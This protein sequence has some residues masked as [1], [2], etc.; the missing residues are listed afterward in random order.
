MLL[1][2][3]D[4]SFNP[5]TQSANYVIRY[6]GQ[7]D[8]LQ[9]DFSCHIVSYAFNIKDF[10]VKMLTL[11]S[12]S[13]T[14]PSINFQQQPITFESVFVYNYKSVT[15]PPEMKRIYISK[16]QAYSKMPQVNEVFIFESSSSSS[17]SNS[18]TVET[19][20]LEISITSSTT[21]LGFTDSIIQI[22]GYFS[23]I[24]YITKVV[25]EGSNVINFNSGL[26]ADSA[27][28]NIDFTNRR[29]SFT[30]PFL[31]QIPHFVHVEI[32]QFMTAI[33]DKLYDQA[34]GNQTI[35][36]RDNIDTIGSRS[37]YSCRGIEV[38]R[39]PSSVKT[40]K[41][42]AFALC[43]DLKKINF[44]S[45]T[46]VENYAFSRCNS[47][48]SITFI[49][50]VTLG[51]RIF[52]FCEK[53]KYVT[54][55]GPNSQFNGKGI[56]DG[57]VK[58]SSITLADRITSLGK[59]MFSQCHSVT[60]ISL[61]DSISVLSERCLHNTSIETFK[62]PNSVVSIG[63]FGVIKTL[64]R[65]Y[66]ESASKLAEIRPDTFGWVN[67]QSVI[68]L[69]FPNIQHIELISN[70][71]FVK[72]DGYLYTKDYKTLIV[73]LPENDQE[74]TII[75]PLTETIQSFAFFNRHNLQNL[76]FPDSQITI[77]SEYSFYN[78]T[79]L[80]NVKLPIDVWVNYSTFILCNN[81][82][83]FCYVNTNQSYITYVTNSGTPASSIGYD[84]SNTPSVDPPDLPPRTAFP[85][86]FA[87]A[88]QTFAPTAFATAEQTFAPTAIPKDSRYPKHGTLEVQ[89]KTVDPFKLMVAAVYYM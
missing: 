46:S 48:E 9:I 6:F 31:L 10:Y 66:I 76:V 88:E 14:N 70:N 5:S 54:F 23:S 45:V 26:F 29:Y 69:T 49:S 36:I 1:Y 21:V 73:C 75:S 81:I 82:V 83:R 27:V 53:I 84:C 40:I 24:S 19:Q 86:A 22:R 78:M 58:L 80:K 68:E 44:D 57:C 15:N 35:T 74:S 43:I 64:K 3:P 51:E 4:G 32:P 8:I 39:L 52:L 28:T 62:I 12:F 77:I 59:E 79:S 38:V 17:S 85:T 34:I 89:E 72:S 37:F 2:S 61:P 60:S 7:R 56:F 50:N 67:C 42:L 25:F 63:F 11:G 41:S 33:P 16:S 20:N 13:S 71:N 65:I 87:T 18:G 55:N 47:L 30:E